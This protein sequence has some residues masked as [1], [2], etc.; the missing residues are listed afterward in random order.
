MTVHKSS[1]FYPEKEVETVDV[2][3]GAIDGGRDPK[4][5]PLTFDDLDEWIRVVWQDGREYMITGK[6]E[7]LHEEP[8]KHLE[9]FALDEGQPQRAVFHETWVNEW[10]SK[11]DAV[12][13]DVAAMKDT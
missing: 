4:E 10:L 8:G 11:T 3:A 6:G 13:F 1:P 9:V 2:F 7:E 12:Y 5:Q